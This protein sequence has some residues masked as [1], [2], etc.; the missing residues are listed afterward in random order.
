MKPWAVSFPTPRPSPSTA[1]MPCHPTEPSSHQPQIYT[2]C[3]CRAHFLRLECSSLSNKSLSLFHPQL[4]YHIS[5]QASVR[6]PEEG[7][8]PFLQGVHT[9]FSFTPTLLC[10]VTYWSLF[11]C[12]ELWEIKEFC[13]VGP[14]MPRAQCS[15]SWTGK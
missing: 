13:L 6:I 2:S 1:C 8:W 14:G 7:F 11:V 4:E 15:T 3:L 5:W 12:L 9:A 10:P